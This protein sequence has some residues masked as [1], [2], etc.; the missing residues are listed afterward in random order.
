MSETFRQEVI[1]HSISLL[2]KRA[3]ELRLSL[4]ELREGM[5]GE[6]KS[7]AGDKHDTAIA[8]VQIECERLEKQLSDILEQES[9]IERL[10]R[11]TGSVQIAEGTLIITNTG[12]F[13]MSVALGKH[14]IQNKEVIY[15]S[16]R[17]PLGAA[18]LSKKV[19]EKVT[20]NKSEYLIQQ[21]L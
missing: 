12:I 17:S 9:K 8:M 11:L 1:Q 7:T 4:R 13:Y 14:L 18:F 3:E 20:F 6:G 16:D 19:G 21:I 10:S 15:L 2:K 5:A